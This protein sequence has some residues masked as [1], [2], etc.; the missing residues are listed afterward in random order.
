MNSFFKN[1]IYYLDD[2]YTGK[3]GQYKNCIDG[4]ITLYASCFSFMILYYINKLSEFSSLEIKQW[5]EYILKHQNE[6]GLFY[7][8]EILKGKLLSDSHSKNHLAWHLTCHVLPV[9]K[10]MEVKPKIPLKFF[11]PYLL[12]HN[13]NKWLK[14]RNWREPWIEGNNLLFMGQ[15]LTYFY[16]EEKVLEAKDRIEQLFKW[17]DEKIDPDTGFWGTQYGS[18]V[19]S[20]VYGGYHQLLLYYYW[21]HEIAHPHKMIDTVLSLQHFD[22]GF[23][24]SWG[25]GSC[26]DVDCVDILVNLYKKTNYRRKDIEKAL[27]KNSFSVLR[28]NNSE[29]GFV[30]KKDSQFYHMG[31]EFTYAAPGRANIFSTWFGINTLLLISEIVKIPKIKIKKYDFNKS[32]S[33]GWHQKWEKKPV[34]IDIFNYTKFILI[35]YVANAYFFIRHVKRKFNTLNK[36]YNFIKKFKIRDKFI[37]ISF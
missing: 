18:N 17:L 6:N 12:E 11:E 33:M 19:Y 22:G 14:R 34:N 32:V 5:A 28:R 25:G 10:I 23:S 35:N 37:F 29:G 24:N 31:M 2:L 3:P 20:S 13:L 26:E 4:E 1:I 15:L 27:I 21:N 9:L 16:E 7:G 36:L 8:P 30:Y